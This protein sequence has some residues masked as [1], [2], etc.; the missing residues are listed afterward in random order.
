MQYARLGDT[1]LI[2]SRLAFGALT[3]TLGNTR[4]KAMA[5]VDEA[6]AGDLVAMALD[7]GVNFFDTADGYAG[8]EA[9]TI[10]GRALRPHRDKVVIATKVGNRNGRKDLLANGLSRRHIVWSVEESLRRLGTDWIDVYIAHRNDCFTPLDETLE[11]FDA[12][13]RSG[14]VRYIAYSNW[15]AWEAATAIAMQRERGLARFTHGQMYYSLLGRD[16]ERDTVPMLAHH[17]AGLTVWSPLAYGFLAGGYTR[18]AMEQD[19]DNRFKNTDWLGFDRD[20]AFAILD[21][22]R[23]IA[24][25]AGCSMA[26]LAIAWLLRKPGVDSVIVGATRAHQLADNL[27]AVDVALP[28]EALALLD[29][30]TA[31]APIYPSSDWVVPDTLT[32]KA[33]ERKG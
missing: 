9:E 17:R 15:P 5:K 13:V 16:V 26:Q 18:E 30:A 4:L 29:A 10:L 32:A 21:V 7:K 1:G 11:A 27:G 33:L 20:R 6:L 24:A 22:M 8:G 19:D 31:N 3:F 2:V 23:P 12:L 28:D 25:Q 14:K